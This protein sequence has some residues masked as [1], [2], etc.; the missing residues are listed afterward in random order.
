MIIR[1]VYATIQSQYG[2]K[3]AMLKRLQ[4]GECLVVIALYTTNLYENSNYFFYF[5][6]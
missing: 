1:R 6:G 5:V 2:L 4:L 3:N